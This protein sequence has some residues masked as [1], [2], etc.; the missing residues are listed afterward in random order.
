M[1][2]KTLYSNYFRIL[3]LDI[4]FFLKHYEVIKQAKENILNPFKDHTAIGMTESIALAQQMIARPA[5]TEQ[6]LYF[7]N[8]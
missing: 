2:K 4:S 5:A 1:Q 7:L 6:E 8:V 3:F